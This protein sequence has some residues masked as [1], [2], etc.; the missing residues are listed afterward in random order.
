[1]VRGFIILILASTISE[2][3]ADAV[4]FVLEKL[5]IGSA[6]AMAVIFQ[7]VSPVSRTGARRISAAASTV[8]S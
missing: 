5:V 8:P 4:E 3:E 2:P 1:M 6:V 7:S